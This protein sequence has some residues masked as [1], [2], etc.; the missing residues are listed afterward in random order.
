MTVWMQLATERP[1]SS[2]SWSME[3]P[4]WGDIRWASRAE[5]D[6]AERVLSVILW[7][8]LVWDLMVVRRGRMDLSM[9]LIEV[10]GMELK[11]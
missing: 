6:L 8:V 2:I 4:V 10:G 11:Y 5:A 3:K 9:Y 1:A 7:V